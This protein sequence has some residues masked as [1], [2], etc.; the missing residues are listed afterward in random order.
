M[1]SR[2]CLLIHDTGSF[3]WLCVGERDHQTK[4]RETD[5]NRYRKNRSDKDT[6]NDEYY[7][8]PS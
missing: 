8:L 3:V 5:S 7:N 2:S 1:T 6:K 4:D